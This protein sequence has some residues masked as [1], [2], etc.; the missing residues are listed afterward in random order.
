M[1]RNTNSLPA[2][3]ATSDIPAEKNI[4]KPTALPFGTSPN[5]PA[6]KNSMLKSDMNIEATATLR[7]DAAPKN[8]ASSLPLENPAP[9]AVP[10]Y[11]N[12]T[13]NAFFIHINYEFCKNLMHTRHL[14]HAKIYAKNRKNMRA[15]RRAY[16]MHLS[17]FMV[18]LCGGA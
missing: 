6:S 2:S 12:A 15:L 17:N 5:F 3:I 8:R 9:I 4:I 10:I 1:L 13:L 14:A 11:K 18:F 7:G 16:S